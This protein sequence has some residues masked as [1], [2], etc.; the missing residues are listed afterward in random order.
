MTGFGRDVAAL[1]RAVGEREGTLPMFL[2]GHGV[3]AVIAGRWAVAHAD[4]VSGLI[5]SSGAFQLRH[6]WLH[7]MAGLVP[8]A[9]CWTYA[10]LRHSR[11]ELRDAAISLSLPLLVVHGSADA[12]TAPAGSECLH[13]RAGTP[14]KTLQIFEGYHH[15]LLTG[16]GRERVR[17][18]MLR[19]MSERLDSM[20]VIEQTR[21]EYINP[22]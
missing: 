12:V 20:N 18:R 21:I 7:A 19:W 22:E 5:L 4:V 3:G 8:S 10:D 6:G 16:T 17:D 1:V 2:L 15:D 11:R 13:G 9:S 14:D